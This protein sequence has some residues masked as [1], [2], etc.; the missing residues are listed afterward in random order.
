MSQHLFLDPVERDHLVAGPLQEL[1][2]ARRG[3]RGC[4]LHHSLASGNDAFRRSIHSRSSSSTASSIGGSSY[5]ASVRFQSAFARA[6]A[7][8]PPSL[9][10]CSKLELS[11]TGER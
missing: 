6:A 9:S 5:S 8:F 7:S 1:G 3:V 11:A 2:G 4:G 10:H